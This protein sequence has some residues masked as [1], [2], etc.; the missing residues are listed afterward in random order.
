MIRYLYFTVYLSLEIKILKKLAVI[1]TT[2]PYS[3]LSVTAL[4]YIESA[5]EKGVEIIGIFFYQD[6]VMHANSD[7]QIANDE[8]QAIKHWQ[9]LYSNYIL[10]LHICITAG[11]KRG[12][13]EL[14][15][16]NNKSGNNIEPIF[17][18]SGLGE[19]IELTSL[20]DRTVQF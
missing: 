11:E 17:T 20:A 1:I 7:I 3:N 5:L 12:L 6:G 14:S 19:L 4:N 18:I 16:S 8:F 10:P 9:R 2:P 13:N 15:S